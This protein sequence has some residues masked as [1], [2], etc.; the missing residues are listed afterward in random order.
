[1]PK[2]H[3]AGIH[4]ALSV[5]DIALS[6]TPD[7]DTC[8]TAKAKENICKA[9]L[10]LANGFLLNERPVSIDGRSS[11]GFLGAEKD[12][13]FFLVHVNGEKLHRKPRGTHIRASE[14]GVE[15][16]CKNNAADAS[17]VE[18]YFSSFTDVSTLQGFE[19]TFGDNYDVYSGFTRTKNDKGNGRTIRNRHSSKSV[20]EKCQPTKSSHATSSSILNDIESPVN[21]DVSKRVSTQNDRKDASQA[22]TL[23]V[24]IDPES[25]IWHGA[26]HS[27][28]FDIKIEVFYNGEFAACRLLTSKSRNSARGNL[29]S[30]FSGKRIHRMAEHAWK[31]TFEDK[32]LDL[33]DKENFIGRWH[34]IGTMLR[35][36]AN[37]REL[38]EFNQKTPTGQF[39]ANL[40]E[41]DMPEALQHVGTES[42]HRMGIIDVVISLGKGRKF[43][44][45]SYYL[46]QPT[47]L[48]DPNYSVKPCREN[49]EVITLA[50]KRVKGSSRRHFKTSSTSWLPSPI[51]DPGVAWARAISLKTKG[52]FE[53][54]S[55]GILSR[56]E[57]STDVN[58]AMTS[59]KSQS[60]LHNPLDCSE[61]SQFLGRKELADQ[62]DSQDSE[63]S[64]SIRTKNFYPQKKPIQEDG[65]SEKSPDSGIFLIISDPAGSNKSLHDEQCDKEETSPIKVS[66]SK[67]RRCNNLSTDPQGVSGS[68]VQCLQFGRSKIL[69]K[70]PPLILDCEVS[71]ISPTA[72]IE[73]NFSYSLG[74]NRRSRVLKTY[75]ESQSPSPSTSELPTDAIELQSQSINRIT[76]EESTFA[77]REASSGA[78]DV[79]DGAV[80]TYAEGKPCSE[81]GH[82]RSIKQEKNGEFKEDSIL[83][84]VRFVLI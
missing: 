81:V 49:S 68:S 10:A 72:S 9:D 36:E 39:L 84:G 13:P 33:R 66:R 41:L 22:V 23:K 34:T 48:P 31:V 17:E 12:E 82:L 30:Y 29:T 54:E 4:V 60:S 76:S 37:L 16:G 21:N 8:K 25:H 75:N 47:R 69:P 26:K 74:R 46:A 7:A 64:P 50:R 63:L 70:K 24:G 6:T 71:T 32:D 18:R 45:N 56:M 53:T 27:A 79:N 67:K 5:S 58:E 11:M 1:M 42:N 77:P 19:T 73:P 40:S 61:G 78:L 59:L 15:T 55:D 35:E 3:S 51:I 28:A 20:L 2:Y 14:D 52:N 43:M 57:K 44:S 62:I 38:N 65:R 83:M 80:A